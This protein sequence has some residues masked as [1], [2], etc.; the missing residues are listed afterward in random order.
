MTFTE[1]DLP[2]PAWRLKEV[3]SSKEIIFVF[4]YATYRTNQEL[5]LYKSKTGGAAPYSA[6][7]TGAAGKVNTDV[8]HRLTQRRW[9]EIYSKALAGYVLLGRKPEMIEEI[10]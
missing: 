3:I 6:S 1:A 4:Q 7:L 9:S 5:W 2:T 8:T 10:F